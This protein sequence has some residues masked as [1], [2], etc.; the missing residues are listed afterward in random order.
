MNEHP[1]VCDIND[2]SIVHAFFFKQSTVVYFILELSI[3]NVV[4]KIKSVHWLG[5]CEKIIIS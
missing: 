5:I 1:Y 2:F 4:V 3:V